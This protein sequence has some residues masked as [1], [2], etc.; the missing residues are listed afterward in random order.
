[1]FS[2]GEK[3]KNLLMNLIVV[4]C[5]VFSIYGQ[6]QNGCVNGQRNG[7][8][9]T[10][11][12]QD[13]GDDTQRLRDAIQLHAGKLIFNETNYTISDSIPLQSY[14]SIEGTNSN[15]FPVYGGSM[16]TQT[17]S[18]KPI[19]T[20]GEG[21]YDVSIRNLSFVAGSGVTNST[22]IF[23]N[24]NNGASQNFDFSNLKFQGLNKGIFVEANGGEYQFDNI[25]LEHSYF[26]GCNTGVHVNSSNSGWH[27]SSINIDAPANGIGFYFEK[28][29]YTSIS[30]VIGGGNTAGLGK[31][32][33]LF[34]IKAHAN[35]SIQNSVSEGFN[36]DIDIDSPSQVG[37]I[38]LM[39]NHFQGKVTVKNAMLVSNANVFVSVPF[40]Q[41]APAIPAIAKGT[42]YLFSTG[43]KFCAYN[44][45]C[46]AGWITQD[47]ARIISEAGVFKNSTTVPSSI[48]RD[49][50]IYDTTPSLSIVAP[51]LAAGPLL[52]LG[53]GTFV[54]DITRSEG[55]VNPGYL[56]FSGNQAVYAGYSFKTQGGTVKINYDGSVT[57]GS[58]V[59]ASLGSPENGTVVYCSNCQETNPCLG[60]GTGAIAKKL[61]N[62]WTCN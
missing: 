27:I 43:D 52:R 9:Y 29:T 44:N 60:S 28:S 26:N 33:K 24:G 53:R 55:A 58:K 21:I 4:G 49:V 5:F 39:N 37:L 40:N 38:Y 16:I 46:S 31:A 10:D 12:W 3:M 32:S 30:L 41:S 2:K 47:T 57:Y 51:T 8:S 19:F 1:L 15:P 34:W 14:R 54:Y 7:I 20:I 25:R 35:M 50:G 45:P 61:P 42:T 23:A 36:E 6:T 18:S 56:E 62:K 59:F 11:C 22:G 13:I 48:T 17:V